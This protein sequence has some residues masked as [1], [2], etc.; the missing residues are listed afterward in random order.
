M[1][2][3]IL[4][5][6][7]SW[8]APA[9][10][11][12]LLACGVLA[13]SYRQSRL[14]GVWRGL[15]LILKALSILGLAVCLLEPLWITQRARTG[16]NY[17]L[18]LADNSLS[19]QIHDR[20]SPTSRGE[21]LKKS[22]NEKGVAWQ[23]QLAKD[24]QVRRYLFD[25]RLQRVESFSEMAFDG[26]SSALN[27]ALKSVRERF[28]NQPL[29]GILL[30]TDGNA[31]DLPRTGIDTNQLPPIYP[32]VVGEDFPARDVSIQGVT[33]SQTAFEDSPVTAQVEVMA[34]GCSSEKITAQL[35]DVSGKQVAELSETANSAESRLNFR[36][37]FKPDKAGLSYYTVRVAA[38]VDLIQF[39]DPKQNREA[40]LANNS[41]MFVV[42]RGQEPFRILYV[43]GRPNWEYKFLNRALQEDSQLQMVALIR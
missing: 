39:T 26:R 6:S 2:A 41:R 32:V 27:S 9:V 3:T 12:S 38:A 13:W 4:L 25:S 42:D 15:C 30:F 10:V 29:A 35:L 17:F 16:A 7:L 31:T 18:I 40:T 11:L 33:A 19:L 37:Q 43:S 34:Y 1:V 5:N 28:A 21:E 36:F 24:F 22:L 8:L 14:R 23:A 20:G